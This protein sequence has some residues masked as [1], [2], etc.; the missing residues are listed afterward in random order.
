ML[1]L[2]NTT[3]SKTIL[4]EVWQPGPTGKGTDTSELQAHRCKTPGQ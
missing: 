3:N 1:L 2:H 4:S